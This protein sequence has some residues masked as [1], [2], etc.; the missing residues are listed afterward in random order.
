MELISMKE[1]VSGIEDHRLRTTERKLRTVTRR[2]LPDTVESLKMGV[3]NHSVNKGN[4]AAIAE[5]NTHVNLYFF[6]GAKLSSQLLEGSGKGMHHIS[7][8]SAQDIN[9]REISRL[10]KQ[11]KK[12]VQNK[13]K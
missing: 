13:K 6:S 12:L 4:V 7:I 10:L 5:Y 11:A 8:K 2:A 1:Y 3:P 9:E